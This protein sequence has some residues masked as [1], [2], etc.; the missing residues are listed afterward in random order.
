MNNVYPY[1]IDNGHGERLTFKGLTQGPGGVRLEADGVA[2]PGAG[3]PMH[4]HYLQEEAARVVH[5]RLGYQVFGGQPQFA[6]PDELVV[7]P[8]GTPHKWWNAGSDELHMTG[9]CSP[10]H[11]VEFFLTTLFSSTKANGGRRPRLF[12]AAFLVTRYRN[13]FALL[14]VPA[15]VRRIVIPI[16]YA[17]GAVLGKY[18]K[19]K[20]APAPVVIAEVVE[21]S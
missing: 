16:V 18:R 9:W 12:D 10:P 19:F 21:A 13:E 5:G 4:V 1:T 7:W 17:F 8:A 15:V 14:E 3:P 11:N 2:Q 6:G 20:D